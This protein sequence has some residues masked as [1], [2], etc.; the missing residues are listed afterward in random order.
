MTVNLVR[1]KRG[2]RGA[3]GHGL[4]G[5]GVAHDHAEGGLVDAVVDA[6]DGFGVGGPLEELVGR[7]VLVN[8]VRVRPK[9]AAQTSTPAISA[10][11]RR[12]GRRR[13][14]RRARRGASPRCRAGA[15]RDRRSSPPQ[16]LGV[17]GGH[18]A[19]VVDP[20][21]GIGRPGL[22]ARLGDGRVHV[23][24][25]HERD[26]HAGGDAVVVDVDAGQVFGVEAQLDGAAD[27]RGVDLV[28]V[29]EQADRRRLGDPAGDRPAER[30]GQHA[31]AAGWPA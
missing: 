15:R 23:A 27:E 5:A 17:G 12:C 16:R 19:Q 26:G 18:Q 13:C 22:A 2:H 21:L 28:A 20:R 31:P 8:G 4:A 9:W 25:D 30:L 14:R 11:P 7:D 29:G 6:G 1:S 3:H 10:P 24:A